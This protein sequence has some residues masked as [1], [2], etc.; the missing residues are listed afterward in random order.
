MEIFQ[1]LVHSCEK[2]RSVLGVIVWSLDKGDCQGGVICLRLG[3]CLEQ[4]FWVG[5]KLKTKFIFVLLRHP[6]SLPDQRLI[7][8]FS[9][10][11]G[12]FAGYRLTF[13]TLLQGSVTRWGSFRPSSTSQPSMHLAQSLHSSEHSTIHDQVTSQDRLTCHLLLYTNLLKL[14]KRRQRERIGCWAGM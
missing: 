7:D 2:N 5:S 9:K 3:V 1:R 8:A 11:F 12:E 10:C 14:F 4:R 6:F 13:G